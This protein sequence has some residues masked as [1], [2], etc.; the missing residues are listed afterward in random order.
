MALFPFFTSLRVSSSDGE[1][2]ARAKKKMLPTSESR[3][4]AV[5]LRSF[6]CENSSLRDMKKENNYEDRKEGKKKFSTS[7][8]LFSTLGEHESLSTEY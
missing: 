7:S 6:R 5:F 2:K 1:T 8:K 3:V 4:F